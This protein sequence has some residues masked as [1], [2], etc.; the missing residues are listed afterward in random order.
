MQLLFDALGLATAQLG[1]P[2]AVGLGKPD[3]QQILTRRPSSA[4]LPMPIT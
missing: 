3:W 4:L 1:F 2:Q